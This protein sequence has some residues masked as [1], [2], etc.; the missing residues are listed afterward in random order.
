MPTPRTLLLGLLAATLLTPAPASAVVGGEDASQAYPNMAAMSDG[1]GEWAGCGGSLVRPDWVLTAAHCVEDAK[2][3]DVA[4]LLGT[5]TLDKPAG[6][7]IPAAQIIVHER[8]GDDDNADS[9]SFD[10]ALVRLAR[11]ATKAAPIRIASPSEKALWAAGRTATVIGWGS[12]D[13]AGLL[14]YPDDLQELDVPMIADDECDAFYPG[15]VGDFDAETMVCAGY[16]EGTKDSCY[17]DSGG[18][19][20]VPD[21]AGRLV[22]VGVVSWGNQCAL[23]TQYGVYSRIGDAP[24][25]TWLESRLP[26]QS[27]TTAGSGGQTAAVRDAGPAVATAPQSAA[28]VTASS[29]STQVSRRPAAKVRTTKRTKTAKAACRRKALRR[30]GAKRK[31][32]LRRCAA[33][34]RT[35]R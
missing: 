31:R 34:K 1:K 2:P 28:P 17:G 5:H 29:S 33:A 35:R 19:L 13:P 23:P 8:W 30:T 27:T 26:A 32:A 9:S 20:M 25:N 22:Q 24:L 15:L 16:T 12:Q 3:E 11:P 10:V 18:P 7:E 21:A 4:W 6:E 14:L